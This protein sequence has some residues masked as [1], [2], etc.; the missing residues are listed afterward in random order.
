[1]IYICPMS[2]KLNGYVHHE[3][4][5]LYAFR[6]QPDLT[7]YRPE[8]VVLDCGAFGA[9][10]RGEVIDKQYASRLAAYY[11]KNP[12]C[13]MY[14]ALDAFQ[15][16][17]NTM[18]QWQN[19]AQMFSGITLTPIIQSSRRGIVDLYEIMRQARFY[20]RDAP[21]A[22]ALSLHAVDPA[23]QTELLREA[24]RMAKTESGAKWLHSLGAG[25]SP[26]GIQM[27]ADMDVYD[28]IDSIAY[29]TAA[30]QN[31]RWRMDGGTE[32]ATED[33]RV[34]AAQNARAARYFSDGT[35]VHN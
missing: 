18:R 8:R 21:N 7:T 19:W 6:S 28:S 30:K 14:M 5:V 25:W 24:G 33:W 34:V 15:D 22:I 10:Q 4:Y 3:H 32:I 12:G 26:R 27:Y 16:P 23:G 35:D 31:E 29:Y 1:M 11:R 13:M 20:K 9:N 17:E 2:A